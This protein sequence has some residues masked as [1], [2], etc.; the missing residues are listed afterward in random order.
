MW[1]RRILFKILFIILPIIY[2]FI[3][4]PL[5]ASTCTDNPVYCKIVKIDGGINKEYAYRLS[6]A[7]VKYSAKYG[8][9]KFL[10]TAI[11]AQESGFRLNAKSCDKGLVFLDDEWKLDE[12]C[13]DF[14]I[15]QI[16]Y[17]NIEVYNLDVELLLTNLD[18]SVEASV[19][20]LKYFYDK[21]SHKEVNWWSRYNASSPNNRALYERRVS[22]FL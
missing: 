4:S 16:N 22:R 7:I 10:L 6:N 9:S 12:V 15:G 2:I 5:S 21:Y 19:V 11:L 13:F 17:R 20:I 1:L 8:V 3:A 14:G 18:Y